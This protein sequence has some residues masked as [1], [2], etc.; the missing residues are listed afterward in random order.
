M[1]I[2]KIVLLV[3]LTGAAG[4][5][6]P[7]FPDLSI[8][9]L[10]AASGGAGGLSAWLAEFLN[11]GKASWKKAFGQCF[12]GLLFA[13][14]AWPASKSVLGVPL[15]AIDVPLA[16]Q[17]MLSAYLTGGFAPLLWAYFSGVLRK[18]TEDDL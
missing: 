15:D 3:S 17:I 4:A 10:A 18:K 6:A 11:A 5:A 14:F 2:Q 7:V 13:A 9:F 16:N 12:L 1:T 8:V